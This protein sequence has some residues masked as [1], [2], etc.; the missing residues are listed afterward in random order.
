M[1]NKSEIK[2]KFFEGKNFQRLMF[3]IFEYFNKRYNYKVGKDEEE[4]CRLVMQSSYTH[5][6]PVEKETRLDYM[7]RINRISSNE[8]KKIISSKL[9]EVNNTTDLVRDDI[10]IQ[11]GD[12]LQAKVANFQKP[13]PAGQKNSDVVQNFDFVNKTRE[14]EVNNVIP[15]V[16]PMF[17]MKMEES[18][19]DILKA[20]EETQKKFEQEKQEFEKSKKLITD[21]NG[22]E[23]TLKREINKPEENNFPVAANETDGSNIDKVITDNNKIISSEDFKKNEL[24]IPQ[25]KQYA[26]VMKNIYDTTTKDYF[27]VIDSRD[28]NNDL[29]PNPNNYQIEFDNVLKSAIAIELVSAELPVVQYNIN[30]N[31]NKL[32]FDEG[33]DEL[34]AEVAIGQYD[35]ISDLT[36]ALQNAL[37]NADGSSMGY[38]VTYSTITRKITLTKG[39][40][41]FNLT[42]EGDTENFVHEQTRTK[43]P[44]GSI[45]PV[46]GFS[47]TNITGSLSYTGDNQYN[48]SGEN[49]VLLYIK[50]LE[51]LESV[52]GNS[53]IHD[54]F[55]KINLDAN[56]NNNI[57]FYKQLDEYISRVS[58]TP[59]LASIGQM[60]IKFYNYD[61][62]FYDFGGR[63]HSLYFKITCFN[64]P[65]EYYQ[66]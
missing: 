54:T 57:K 26:K 61:G 5:N 11:Q 16:K 33:S 6:N 35:T 38:T 12:K 7:K 24:I 29:Y 32:H 19:E 31:N 25:P 66:G 58:F 4:L 14:K 52:S 3:R 42:F 27:I 47:R 48:L 39:S 10:L 53:V 8:L 41:T 62:S 22:N 44:Q 1:F 49:Y 2:R 65:T 23:I 51:N 50:E 56:N 60:I 63:E 21:A 37:N 28:R 59:P 55:T 43:Y 13:L 40:G 15:R 20:F 46:I 36:L 45:G 9:N 34:V 18:N 64:Q 30:E 17:E